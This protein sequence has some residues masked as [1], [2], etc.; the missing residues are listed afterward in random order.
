MTYKTS[1][2]R[3]RIMAI[4]EGVSYLLFGVTMPLKYV[5]GIPEPNYVVGMAH[6]WFFLLYIYLCIRN[7]VSYRWSMKLTL[8][9]L[10]ASLLPLATF[11]ADV[12]IFKLARPRQ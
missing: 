9:A 1:I 7:A 11:F 12:K 5:L 2:G 10:A 8:L 4:L 6:G 3:L